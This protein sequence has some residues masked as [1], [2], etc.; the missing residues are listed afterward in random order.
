MTTGIIANTTALVYRDSFYGPDGKIYI[1]PNNGSA[2]VM[3]VNPAN[4][5]VTNSNNSLTSVNIQGAVM[6]LD[7]NIYGG[8]YAGSNLLQVVFNN[9]AYKFDSNYIL[10]PYVNHH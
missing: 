10:S 6:G 7:G 9:V 5:T 1:M 8:T 4:N 3:V 2:T